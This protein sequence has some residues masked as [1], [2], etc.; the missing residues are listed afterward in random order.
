MAPE[1]VVGLDLGEV[2]YVSAL[3][4]GRLLRIHQELRAVSVHLTIC[5]L[6]PAVQRLFG[7]TPLDQVFQIAPQVPDGPAVRWAGARLAD[8]AEVEELR[9]QLLRLVSP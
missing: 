3:G 8:A 9:H 5:G 6:T 4:G 2:R 1:R 7:V